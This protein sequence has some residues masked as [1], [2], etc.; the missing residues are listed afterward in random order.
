LIG[1]LNARNAAA[2]LEPGSSVTAITKSRKFFT[3]FLFHRPKT[4]AL[5]MRKR[6]WISRRI[7][8]KKTDSS[9]FDALVL[10]IAGQKRAGQASELSRMKNRAAFLSLTA[11]LTFNVLNR[12]FFQAWQCED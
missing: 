12:E 8:W 4:F 6:A 9:K 5:L 3:I 10:C 2:H 1:L 11:S 7:G